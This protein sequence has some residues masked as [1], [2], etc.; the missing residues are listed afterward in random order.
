M[1]RDNVIRNCVSV[2]GVHLNC[3][4]RKVNVLNTQYVLDTV[5]DTQVQGKVRPHVS[6]IRNG[7]TW[8]G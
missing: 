8:S 3:Q 1:Q 4:K 6:I 2:Y 7:F 5:L